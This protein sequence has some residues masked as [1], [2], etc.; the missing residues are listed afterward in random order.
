MTGQRTDESPSEGNKP[1]G[2][3]VTHLNYLA[4]RE[5]AADLT[6]AAERAR[7]ARSA[8][9]EGPASRRNGL[10]ARVLAFARRSRPLR[11]STGGV[12]GSSPRARNVAT[13]AVVFDD[14]D[15]C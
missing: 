9:G 6:R 8:A 13:P 3:R 14:H 2:T 11:P 10:V 4:A 5:R 7:L 15:G 12:R 1:M